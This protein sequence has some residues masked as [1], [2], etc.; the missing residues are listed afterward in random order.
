MSENISP[1]GPSVVV[2]P[3]Q[4][5]I[6]LVHHRQEIAV[7]PITEEQLD[8]LGSN[9]SVHLGFFM[10]TFGVCITSIITLSTVTNMSDRMISIYVACAILTFILSL[11]FGWMAWKDWQNDK[12]RKAQIKIRSVRVQS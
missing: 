8:A 6:S 2:L 10:F 5:S 3:A 12:D 11:Y 7:Y 9:A 4:S 1:S